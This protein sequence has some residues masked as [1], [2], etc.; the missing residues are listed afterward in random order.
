MNV[1]STKTYY[2]LLNE[3]GK[4]GLSHRN[5]IAIASSITEYIK[6]TKGITL[7]QLKEI[8]DAIDNTIIQLS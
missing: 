4:E 2:V 5:A 1:P 8:R 6:H 3:L 7:S